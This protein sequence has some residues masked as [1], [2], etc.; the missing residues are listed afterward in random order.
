VAN[1]KAPAGGPFE[2]G[3]HIVGDDGPEVFTPVEPSYARFVGGEGTFY[4]G[5]PARD[6]TRAE[7]DELPLQL[8][9]AAIITQ[10]Y[11]VPPAAK[12]AVTKALEPATAD[13]GNNEA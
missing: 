11:A 9:H 10:L 12:A 5:I 2:A 1:K 7:W 4:G 13:Q 8:Q 6:L 3:E